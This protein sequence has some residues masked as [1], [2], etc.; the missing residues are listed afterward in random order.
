M[1]FILDL[2]QWN[3]TL[4]TLAV[5]EQEEP[6]DYNSHD[7]PRRRHGGLRML[8]E[9]ILV[10]SGNCTKLLGGLPQDLH[11]HLVI[12]DALVQSDLQSWLKWF[13]I[14]TK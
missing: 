12:A 11:L 13:R 4:L 7:A 2:K 6:N 9:G 14:K 3:W 10:L 8:R 1:K 5:K